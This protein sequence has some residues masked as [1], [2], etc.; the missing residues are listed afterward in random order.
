MQT[1]AAYGA[2]VDDWADLVMLGLTADL[3]P[4][5][6][7]PNATIS[8]DSKM[9]SIGKTPSRFNSNRQVAGFS[10]W[11]S[12]QATQTDINKWSKEPDYGI[13]IQTRTVRAIDCDITDGTLA[14]AIRS[15]I[16]D[17]IGELPARTRGN[18]PK[19]LL[20]FRTSG[21]LSKRIITT[22]AGNIEFL[23]TG[24]QFIAAGTHPSGSRYEWQNGL[25]GVIPELTLEQ[26][27]TL[28]A[29]LNT[30]FGIGESHTSTP[31]S[32]VKKLSDV[33]NADPVAQY[34]LDKN[35]VKSMG[36]DGK[37]HIDCP[38]K[39][40]HSMDS[41][42]TETAYYPAHTGG[43]AKGHFKCLHAHCEHRDDHEFMD[44]IGFISEDAL[45]D[46]AAIADEVIDQPNTPKLKFQFQTAHDFTQHAPPRWIVKGVLPEAQLGVVYGDSGSGKTFF[47]LDLAG[48]IA[49]GTEWRGHR[50]NKRRVA[51]VV[52]EGAGGFRNRLKAY[53]HQHQIDL[54]DF[55]IMVLDGAPN[56]LEKA[57]AVELSKAIIA[58]GGADIVV[59]DTFAQ[60][61]AGANENSG[62]DVGK[63]LAHCKGI[64][65]A[66][67]ALVVLIHHSGKDASKGARGWSGLRA[68]ADVEIEISRV[69]ETRAATV[70]KLKDGHDGAEFGFRLNTV[71]VG[72]DEDDEEVSSCIL[73][74]NESG[75]PK[76]VKE[77]KGNNER[78]ALRVLD[79][80][81]AL[82][83]EGVFVEDVVVQMIGQI[84]KEEGKRD[85]RR[86]LCLKAVNSLVADGKL[87]SV[88]GKLHFGGAA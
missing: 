70:T 36:R 2:T 28:W 50:V 84:V 55:D 53:A 27:N 65:R 34:L 83:D 10:D 63:A 52:A 57:D 12:Y 8:P 59:L 15:R 30:E 85:R 74:H 33:I 51:Y 88:E 6:S 76:R 61:M 40:E 80:L 3:L 35:L 73:E 71:V 81:S 86:E 41:G 68:A 29:N 38:W 64:N 17:H 39:D 47:M 46:F 66:T 16:A 75:R 87:V 77:P 78:L 5:V 56:M 37:L 4:V 79:E 18:S 11:T 44:R 69:D 58:A 22:S 72:L 24:Q 32:K 82:T 19:F 14:D 31:S 20:A 23:A 7:D 45:A 42:D 54:R 67:K 21:Q 1:I 43:Y 26:F 49:R 60:V 48:S 25:P 13:C 62:E 9:K